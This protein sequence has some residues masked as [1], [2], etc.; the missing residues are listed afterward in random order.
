MQPKGLCLPSFLPAYLPSSLPC[1]P[2][3]RYLKDGRPGVWYAVYLPRDA[4]GDSAG[5]SGGWRGF[6]IDQVLKGGRGGEEGS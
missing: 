6:A 1:L 3:P 2:R 5:L 4:S